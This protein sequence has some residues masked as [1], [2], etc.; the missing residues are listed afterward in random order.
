MFRESPPLS[1]DYLKLPLANFQTAS[2]GSHSEAKPL[3]AA[4]CLDEFH[5]SFQKPNGLPHH[6][7]ILLRL[8]MVYADQLL[9]GRK[10]SKHLKNIEI[11]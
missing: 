5:L 4:D 1:Q 6:R 3:S 9:G 2:C 8:S 11:Q 10:W 7:S